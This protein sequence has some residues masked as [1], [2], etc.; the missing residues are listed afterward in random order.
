MKEI[1]PTFLA[2][3]AVTPYNEELYT[4]TLSSKML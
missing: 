3:S 4:L 2:V 1:I